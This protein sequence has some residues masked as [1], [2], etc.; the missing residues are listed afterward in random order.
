MSLLKGVFGIEDK[1]DEVRQMPMALRSSTNLSP[2]DKI[3][4]ILG[5]GGYGELSPHD[6]VAGILGSSNSVSSNPSDKVRNILGT[7]SGSS[8]SKGQGLVNINK[9]L[10]SDKST[11]GRV[12]INKILG[13]GSGSSKSNAGKVN[14]NKMLGT[15]KSNAGKVK[16]NN[17][18]GISRVNSGDRVRN[19]IS[20]IKSKSIPNMMFQRPRNNMKGKIRQH[21]GLSSFGDFDGDGVKNILDCQPRNPR[22]QGTI[23]KVRNWLGGKGYQ[24]DIKTPR[25]KVSKDAYTEHGDYPTT[26]EKD[27]EQLGKD[28]VPAAKRGAAA[29]GR[30]V[31]SLYPYLGQGA[32]A[33]GRGARALGEKAG[34]S[35]KVSDVKDEPSMSIKAKILRSVGKKH[36][37]ADEVSGMEE[38][39]YIEKKEPFSDRFVKGVEGF[40]RGARAAYTA[41]DMATPFVKGVNRGGDIQAASRFG[42]GFRGD[43]IA[44]ADKLAYLA[45]SG[46]YGSTGD[47][48]GKV[49]TLIGG[50]GSRGSGA[51]DLIKSNRQERSFKSRA[52]EALG[53]PHEEEIMPDIRSELV[54]RTEVPLGQDDEFKKITAQELARS[55]RKQV[56]GRLEEPTKPKYPYKRSFRGGG[57]RGGVTQSQPMLY[58]KPL[59]ELPM[60]SLGSPDASSYGES[61]TY[62]SVPRTHESE[63]YDPA[64]LTYE[65]AKA[66]WPDSRSSGWRPG[67]YWSTKSQKWV[68]YLRRKYTSHK[69]RVEDEY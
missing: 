40:G 35:V 23:H 10:G 28:F 45:G 66:R 69:P 32:R 8:S 3:G 33:T 52:S 55:F 7:S 63:I 68:K 46:G 39:K 17:M 49:G 15:D 1:E 65:E 30:G 18:L 38:S 22:E 54:P 53:L 6:K 57:V 2:H 21:Q 59:S 11:A 42:V 64:P 41:F 4:S 12:N 31:A 37:V 50:K 48:A 58:G 67:L 36:S 14:I 56:R 19:L 25:G 5:R 43:G 16:I 27:I 51:L 26:F 29:V 24:E 62:D 34:I 61:D 9:I 44:E 60:G 13:T 47:I 20:G